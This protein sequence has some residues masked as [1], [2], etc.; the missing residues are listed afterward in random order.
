MK[1]IKEYV[2]IITAAGSILK[3]DPDNTTAK[4]IRNMAGQ[5]LVNDRYPFTDVNGGICIEVGPQTFVIDDETPGAG[6]DNAIITQLTRDNLSLKARVRALLSA[7][8]AFSDQTPLTAQSG[9][10]EELDEEPAEDKTKPAATA[11]PRATPKEKPAK[12]EPPAQGTAKPPIKFELEPSAQPVQKPG[13]IISPDFTGNLPDSD[14]TTILNMFKSN[15]NTEKLSG[16]YGTRIAVNDLA[17]SEHIV[18]IKD[19]NGVESKVTVVISPLSMEEG[20][21]DIMAWIGNDIKSEVRVSEERKSVLL[22]LGSVDLVASGSVTNGRFEGKVS[23]T[24]NMASKGITVQSSDKFTEGSGHILIE[25]EG[26]C[27]H[28][29]PLSKNNSGSGNAEFFYA[30]ME[31]DKSAIVGDNMNGKGTIPFIYNNQ[32]HTL[33]LTW[34][35]GVLIGGVR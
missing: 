33:K 10:P 14:D 7:L 1:N 15:A 35:S 19:P 21:S 2:D 8:S 23:T 31:K 11:V 6:P 27:I 13:A 26:I 32:S 20:E 9:L 4:A 30:I 29:V 17:L 25:D 22:R 5:A 24:K 28:A 3:T 12:K 18:T 16:C 34:R